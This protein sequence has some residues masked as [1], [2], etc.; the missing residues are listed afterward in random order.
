MGGLTRVLD[1]NHA[2]LIQQLEQRKKDPHL[3]LRINVVSE[4]ENR[5]VRWLAEDEAQNRSS[6][7]LFRRLFGRA[8]S[9]GCLT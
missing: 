5:L 1:P 2:G 3:V 9:C 7:V 8:K 6:L 4:N